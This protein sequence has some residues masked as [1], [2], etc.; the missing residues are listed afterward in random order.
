MPLVPGVKTWL[1][2]VFRPGRVCSCLDVWKR[3]PFTSKPVYDFTLNLKPFAT[4]LNSSLMDALV[5]ACKLKHDTSL[6]Y[7]NVRVTKEYRRTYDLLFEPRNKIRPPSSRTL[8]KKGIMFV[9][10]RIPWLMPLLT[11]KFPVPKRINRVWYRIVTSYWNKF[12]ENLLNEWHNLDKVGEH[13]YR[14]SA[15]LFW[16]QSLGGRSTCA[17]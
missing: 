12:V 9:R 16:I 4:C 7:W 2:V 17:A 1:L 8:W 10:G 15:P 11:N 14:D 6:Y 3:Y 5:C 13:I